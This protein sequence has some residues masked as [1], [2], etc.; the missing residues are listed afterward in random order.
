[1]LSNILVGQP[2]K[3]QILS[4]KNQSTSL[5]KGNEKVHPKLEQRLSSFFSNKIWQDV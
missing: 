1:M 4:I 5:N 2:L 3:I